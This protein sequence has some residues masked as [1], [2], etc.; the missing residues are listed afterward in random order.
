MVVVYTRQ[1]EVLLLNRIHPAGFWQS[2]TGSLEWQEIAMQAA[3][4]ELYEETGIQAD[5][6]QDCLQTNRFPILPEWRHRYAPEVTENTETVFR[7]E[8]SQAR[9]ITLDPDEHSEYMWLPKAQA[10]KQ[11]ASWTNRD[12]ILAL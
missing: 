2:I 9:D 11:V 7:L 10:A 8:L 3:I 6:L 1:S 4:R 5:T 12:A